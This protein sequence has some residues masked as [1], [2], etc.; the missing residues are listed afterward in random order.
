[1]ILK[2]RKKIDHI[3]SFGEEYTLADLKKVYEILD[4]ESD[5]SESTEMTDG[6]TQCCGYD[7]GTECFDKK[8]KFCPCCGRKIKRIN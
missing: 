3:S 5:S 6:I 8:I 4:N 2:L 1:M 7:F